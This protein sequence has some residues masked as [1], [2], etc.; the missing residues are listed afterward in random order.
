VPIVRFTI[1]PEA[2]LATPSPYR[3]IDISP[4]GAHL[5]YNTGTNPAKGDVWIRAIDQLEAVQLQGLDT[6][7]S[8]FFSAD[9]QWIGFFSPRELQKVSIKG[10]SPTSIGRVQGVPQGASWNSRNTIVFATTDL[11]TGL[12]TVSADGGEPT[13]LT[14][15]NPA[16]GEVDHLFP[17][18]LPSGDAV[19]FTVTTKRGIAYS[20]VT[21]LDLKTGK[22]KPLI[23]GGSGARYIDTGH[24]VYASAAA[25]RVVRFDPIGLNVL[26]DPVQVIDRVLIKAFGAPDFSV[27]AH[28]TLVYVA[29]DVGPPQRS[30]V[31]VD[32]QGHEERL[33]VPPRAYVYARLSPDATRVALDIRIRTTIS[34]CGISLMR[35]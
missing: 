20:E 4:D 15:P 12:L 11:S 34:G 25:L 30:L 6:P 14:E 2:A 5:V 16:D 13:V 23:R 31:W 29:G 35:T 24:L 33:N 32:R 22:R 8:P 9:N 3:D 17:S 1:T 19:L 26:S 18:F 10:G 21:V 7:K 27:S 28:G